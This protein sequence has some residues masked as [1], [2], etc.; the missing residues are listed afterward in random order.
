MVRYNQTTTHV[1]KPT[2]RTHD[3]KVDQ[4]KLWYKSLEACIYKAV[5]SV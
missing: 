2:E 5:V 1:F 4:I 3:M